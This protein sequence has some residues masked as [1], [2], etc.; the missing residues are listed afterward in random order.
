[1]A[2]W[3]QDI[4]WQ[5]FKFP[6]SQTF[7]DDSPIHSGK[8]TVDSSSYSSILLFPLFPVQ[9][10]ANACNE[11]HFCLSSLSNWQQT[12]SHPVCILWKRTQPFKKLHTHTQNIL[13]GLTSQQLSTET[14]FTAE[15]QLLPAILWLRLTSLGVMFAL[16][17]KLRR[18]FHSFYVLL[19]GACVCSAQILEGKC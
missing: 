4:Q 15:A 3:R 6:I 19:C 11:F 1:M 5:P 7:Y 17:W 13:Q 12:P 10:T 8:C 9:F 14:V 16:T 18:G 2:V